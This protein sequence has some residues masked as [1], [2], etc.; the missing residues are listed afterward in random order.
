MNRLCGSL[1]KGAQKFQA[2]EQSTTSCASNK[3]LYGY[4]GTQF[5][6]WSN[7]WQAFPGTTRPTRA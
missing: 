3:Q 6:C 7:R 5:G 1:A 2:L 4:L